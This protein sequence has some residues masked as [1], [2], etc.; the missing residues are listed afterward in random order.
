M[1]AIKEKAEPVEVGDAVHVVDEHYQEH[2]GLVTTVHGKFTET[3]A[4]CINV[5]YVSSDPAK[6]DPYGHQLERMSS[7][8]HYAQGPSNMPTPGRYWTN[9]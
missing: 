8:Q 2:I 7:L 6:R 1:T 4:P 3:F 5:V 9:L